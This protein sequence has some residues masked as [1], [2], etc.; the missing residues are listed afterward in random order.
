VAK[1][2]KKEYKKRTKK[3]VVGGR[4]EWIM[5]SGLKGYQKFN[6]S[7]I[8]YKIKFSLQNFCVYIF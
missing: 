3:V 6:K 5:H 4:D 7:Y 1:E 2:G 8:Q